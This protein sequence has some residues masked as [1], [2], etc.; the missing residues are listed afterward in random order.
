MEAQCPP[1]A[2][3]FQQCTALA[4]FG[5]Q[6]EAATT[7]ARDAHVP[8]PRVAGVKPILLLQ[9]PTRPAPKDLQ[10]RI[11]EHVTVGAAAMG[12]SL[13][14]TE[15]VKKHMILLTFSPSGAESWERITRQDTGG[16]ASQ[17]SHSSTVNASRTACFSGCF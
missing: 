6:T 3:V 12:H 5:R 10:R 9:D 2:I 1:K 7:T 17:E 14:S 11:P 13:V 15:N 4:T 8:S 16:E